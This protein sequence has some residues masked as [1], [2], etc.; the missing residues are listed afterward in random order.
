MEKL[1]EHMISKIY[2]GVWGK[3]IGVRLGMP[4]EN[5]KGNDVMKTYPHIYGFLD[6]CNS[7]DWLLRPDDDINGF[8]FFLKVLERLK[9]DEEIQPKH[10][11]DVI[12]DTAND[13]PF[14][15][16]SFISPT[17]FWWEDYG[18]E[19]SAYRNLAAGVPPEEIGDFAHIGDACN[20]IGGEIFYDAVGLVFAGDAERAVQYTS[21]MAKV[22]HNGEG[23]YGG[24]FINACISYAFLETSTKVIIEKA[25]THIPPESVLADMV[26]K[27]LA[28][29]EKNPYDWEAALYYAE[30]NWPDWYIWDYTALIVLAL[31]YGNGNFSR[32]LEICM[33][34]G[35]DT[36]CTCGN[37]GTILGV[38]NGYENINYQRWVEPFG[39]IVLCSASTGYE[40]EVSVTQYAARVLLQVCNRYLF[41][42]PY[43]NQ[44]FNVYLHRNHQDWKDDI[45]RKN[46]LCTEKI[47]TPSGAPYALKFWAW[48]VKAGDVYQIYRHFAKLEN[49]SDYNYTP[50]L[51]SHFLPGQTF[52]VRVRT[53]DAGLFV[54]LW[55]FGSEVYAG[56]PSALPPDVWQE[57][58]LTLPEGT[59][60]NFYDFINIEVYCSQDSFWKDDFNGIVVW[61]DDAS[62]ENVP[63]FRIQSDWY[64]YHNDPYCVCTHARLCFGHIVQ[65]SQE[66]FRLMHG[67]EN[68]LGMLLTGQTDKSNYQFHAVLSPEAGDLHLINFA[69]H[70]I[71][72][73]YAFGFYGK[74]LL[75]LLKTN[76]LPGEYEIVRQYPF[77]WEYGRTYDFEIN[78]REYSLECRLNHAIVL[79]HQ[80][81]KPCSGGVGF[82]NRNGSTEIYLQDMSMKSLI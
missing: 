40:N 5:W 23:A 2:G 80:T 18:A 37:L 21:V 44:N 79:S 33:H 29:Y 51:C 61:L 63:C 3:L 4:V 16:N 38:L 32:S 14:D 65:V 57:F 78:V 48:N 42:F 6:N 20:H 7:N 49:F 17:F 9:P 8:I 28:F 19:K 34:C 39:D 54:K 25:L 56:E 11:A 60:K 41:A 55:A 70:G 52:R 45:C 47:S 73:H 64:S 15:E 81:E 59:G 71:I 24:M 53:P 67:E 12:L 62:V 27:M 58:S 36:D 10:M 31:L 76:G 35:R 66:K 50:S 72:S 30:E 46:S 26:R 13:L 68:Q 74:N 82:V 1:P 75:A 22:M 69:V 43:S 77:V